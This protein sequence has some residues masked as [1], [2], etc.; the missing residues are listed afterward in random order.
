MK[1]RIFI[2]STFYDLKYIR[3]DLANFIR[4]HD[5]E[6]ILFED[7]DIG[8]TPFAHLDESCYRAME[9]ADMALLIIGGN[10]GSP[11]TGES[12]SNF[13]DFLSV[14]RKEFRKAVDKGIPVYVFIESGVYSEYGIYDLN[15]REIESK[16]CS[17]KFKA[18]KNINVFRFIKEIHSLNDIAIT[19]FEKVSTIKE[20]L[21][22]QWADMFKSHLSAL[23]Q[24]K[25]IQQLQDSIGSMNIIVEKMDKL[26]DAISKK[27]FEN[28]PDEKIIVEEREKA[29]AKN[30]CLL[31][32]QYIKIGYNKNIV[33]K[34]RQQVDILLKS[35]KVLFEK[36]QMLCIENNISAEDF[37]IDMAN[38]IMPNFTK[39]LKES[40]MR[41]IDCNFRI[42][43]LMDQ[44][45][46]YLNDAEKERDLFAILCV[47][48]YYYRI[49]HDLTP[50]TMQEEQ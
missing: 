12:E 4:N 11:A 44:M 18:A 37:D 40:G 46:P 10:Y 19:S 17:I 28:T 25:E 42:F 36:Q 48:P 2:S 27:L 9:S 29:E 5:F 14:T 3:E 23:K 41:L 13:E 32:S 30:I 49:F 34:R 16:V 20:F 15:C 39:S 50:Q 6:P 38:K 45:L 8:Y 31:L 22:K 33:K 24:Q 26:V 43:T 47:A 1:P 21:S 35:L 7:G